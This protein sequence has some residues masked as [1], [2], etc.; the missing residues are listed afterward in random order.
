MG[1]P[2]EPA[3]PGS[4]CP[5]LPDIPVPCSCLRCSCVGVQPGGLGACWPHAA[6]VLNL[7]PDCFLCCCSLLPA[8][9]CVQLGAVT[10][11]RLRTCWSTAAPA[12]STIWRSCKLPAWFGGATARGSAGTI[13]APR[14]C[15]NGSSHCSACSALLP[16]LRSCAAPQHACLCACSWG[17]LQEM[18][19]AGQDS[20]VGEGSLPARLSV[21]SPEPPPQQQLPQL[22][23]LSVPLSCL[24]LTSPA[25]LPACLQDMAFST[26]KLMVRAGQQW[27]SST[28]APLL[29][30]RSLAVQ[31]AMR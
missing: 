2:G 5:S 3:S 23:P 31:G 13:L 22:I 12:H 20:T 21:C 28:A 11:R 25:C 24:H 1:R 26:K 29:T 27:L 19:A 17:K 8:P 6:P 30:A 14:L 18:E 7:P 15:S 4:G 10:W 9:L 16:F